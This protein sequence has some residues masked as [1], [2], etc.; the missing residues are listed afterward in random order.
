MKY[1]RAVTVKEIRKDGHSISWSKVKMG[2]DCQGENKR[3]ALNVTER[4]KDG[5][6]V[7]ERIRWGSHSQGEKEIWVHTV[8]DRR[9]FRLSGREGKMGSNCQRENERWALTF[10]ERR[11]VGL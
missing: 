4:R 10:R 3:W 9:K 2:S 8:R 5:L 7:V 11:K 6:C 1:T